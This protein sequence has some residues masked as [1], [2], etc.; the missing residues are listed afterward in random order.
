M[1]H[2]LINDDKLW[3]N[4]TLTLRSNKNKCYNPQQL[5]KIVFN[6]VPQREKV[7]IIKMLRIEI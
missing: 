2:R 1:T 4:K 3:Y 5:N 7:S 6:D